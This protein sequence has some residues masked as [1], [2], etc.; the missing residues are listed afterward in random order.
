MKLAGDRPWND[1]TGLEPTG[2]VSNYFLGDDPKAW[3]TKIPHYKRVS[4]GAVYDGIDMVFYTNGADLEYDC[5]VKPGADPKKI[6]LAFEG[7]QRMRVD[8]ASGNLVVTTPAG[9]ELR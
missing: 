5:V 4:V 6:R 9:S 7:Q 1:L 2:G 8:T 3:R